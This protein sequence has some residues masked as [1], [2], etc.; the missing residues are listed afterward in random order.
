MNDNNG[1]PP[2]M[3]PETVRVRLLAEKCSTCIF[4]PGNLMH[5]Q[6]GRRDQM[7]A[8]AIA[9]DGWITCHA[10]LPYGQH[11]DAEPA[12]CRGFWDVHRNDS[13]FTRFAAY[14]GHFVEVPQPGK[15]QE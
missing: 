10:T 12:V 4:R 15:D 13:F 3:D 14:T 7:S 9:E 1:L 5:L 6:P 8:E 11:P 2:V